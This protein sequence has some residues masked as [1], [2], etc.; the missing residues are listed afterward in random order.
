MRVTILALLLA[1]PALASDLHVPGDAATIAGAIAL[2]QDGDTIHVAPG[3]WVGA[4]D[5]GGKTLRLGSDGGFAVTTIDGGAADYAVR[6][7]EA[8]GICT[9]TGFTIV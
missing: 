7:P 1:S 9:L 2:A 6:I 5:F 3:T 8:S 4:V